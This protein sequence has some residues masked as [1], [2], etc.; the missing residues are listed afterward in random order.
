MNLDYETYQLE[1]GDY[2]RRFRTPGD[3]GGRGLAYMVVVLVVFSPA[4]NLE[5]RQDQNR[6]ALVA[7]VIDG[8]LSAKARLPARE[9]IERMPHADRLWALRRIAESGDEEFAP[10]AVDALVRERDAVL[11]SVVRERAPRWSDN[12]VSSL[13]QSLP[14]LRYDETLGDIPLI[15]MREYV[16]HPR[17][18][19]TAHPLVPMQTIDLAACLASLKPGTETV[20]VLRRATRQ[21]PKSFG[22]WIAI[23][24]LKAVTSADKVIARNVFL[25]THAPDA[26][27]SAAAVVLGK[28]DEESNCWLRE[29]S[30]TFVAAYGEASMIEFVVASREEGGHDAQT[31][32]R[33]RGFLDGLPSL[34]VS[35]ASDDAE[36]LNDLTSWCMSKNEEIGRTACLTLVKRSPEQFMD[37]NFVELKR[38]RPGAEVDVSR[39]LAAI[40]IYHPHLRERALPHVTAQELDAQ[41]LALGEVGVMLFGLPGLALIIN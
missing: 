38:C 22:P 7:T 2:Q 32:E 14:T 23:A 1:R 18:L 35:C 6:D 4:L 27:R 33:Y 30:R 41:I 40:V 29:Q 28:D 17:E 39:F 15:I 26:A 8:N 37:L 5:A 20:D 31:R 34:I 16:E 10:A 11:V 21:Y 12:M 25:D 19:P 9:A 13:L 24:K 36:L 3:R